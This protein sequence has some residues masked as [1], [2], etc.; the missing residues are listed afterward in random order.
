MAVLT[1]EEQEFQRN[2]MLGRHIREARID[3]GWIV[4]W[5]RQ[6]YRGGKRHRSGCRRSRVSSRGDASAADD[7]NGH[8][9]NCWQCSALPRGVSSAW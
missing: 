7:R 9:A 5:L 2:V 4:D 1:H 8:I 6:G 3:T